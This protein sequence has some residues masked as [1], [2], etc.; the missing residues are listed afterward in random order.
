MTNEQLNKATIKVSVDK[1][2]D[3]GKVVFKVVGKERNE[4]LLK[5]VPHIDYLDLAIIFYLYF[6]EDELYGYGETGGLL[7]QNSFLDYWKVDVNTLMMAAMENTPKH[8]GLKIRGIFST[9]ATYLNDDSLMDIAEEE[10]KAT[11]LYVAT[12]NSAL[13][14]AG[15]LIYKDMLKAMAA[16]LDSDLF[17]IPCSVHE[18]IIGKIMEDCDYSL[19]SLKEMI[20]YVNRHDLLEEDVLSD[21]LYYYKRSTGELGIV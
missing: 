9:I 5:M 1:V 13:Y 10:D 17:I 2:L 18:I 15:V 12:N 14:G 19:D 11:P 20:W 6:K 3:L 16:K 4:E 21:N 7:I 8:L